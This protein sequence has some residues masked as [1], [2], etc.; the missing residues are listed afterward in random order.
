MPKRIDSPVERF[1][2][3]V[4]LHDPLTYPQLFA[5]QDA[6]GEA[7][8]LGDTTWMK[9]RYSLLPGILACV[10]EWNLEGIPEEPNI[11]N[12][13]AT[14]IVASGE[15]IN[16]LQEQITALLTEAETVPNE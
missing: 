1:P 13:P 8:E 7:S 14:P 5:F 16:W 3:S 15:V 9:V 2:G 4:T 12:F 6:I 11:D 10:A